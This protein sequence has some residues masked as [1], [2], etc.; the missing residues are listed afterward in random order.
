[1]RV[2]IFGATMSFPAQ[3]RHLVLMNQ[4]FFLEARVP[5]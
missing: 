2:E 5:S 4:A 3:L 1:M